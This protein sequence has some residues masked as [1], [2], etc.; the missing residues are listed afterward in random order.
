MRSVRVCHG[1]SARDS[2]TPFSMDDNKL[3]VEIEVKS[4]DATKSI[5]QVDASLDSLGKK[6][7][8]VGKSATEA[9]TGFGSMLKSFGIGAAVIGGAGAAFGQLKGFISDSISEGAQF[10][11][12]QAQLA[13]VLSSTGN[14][15]GFTAKQIN[16][17]AGRMSDLSAI[18]DDVILGAQ[19]MLLT[20]TQLKGQAFE[21]ATQAVLDM[22]TAMAGGGV[23]SMEQ[24]R[25]TAL[26]VGKALNDPAKGL[27]MLTRAGVTFTDQQEKQINTMIKAGNTMGAQKLML[28]ELTKEFGGSAA[29]AALTYEGRMAKL[30]NAVGD[31]KKNIGLAIIAGI[32]P[33]I[34]AMT[35]QA[36]GADKATQ[37]ISELSYAVYGVTTVLRGLVTG[38]KGV[39]QAFGVLVLGIIG[40][41]ATIFAFAK[42]VVKNFDAIK[43]AG[44]SMAKGVAY[45]LTGQFDD[46]KA[47]FG[48]LVNLDFSN[49]AAK[50]AQMANMVSGAWGDVENTFKEA[51]ATFKDA[52]AG[53]GLEASV[54]QSEDAAK[55][56]AEKNKQ[57]T[58]L[59]NKMGSGA[60]DAG[61]KASDAFKKA[62]S[63]LKD[64]ASD[65]AKGI[66]ETTE[67]YVNRA[68]DLLDAYEQKV[69]DV[70]KSI[71]EEN[72]SY[73]K[74]NLNA[75]KDYNN[76]VLALFIKEQDAHA[77]LLKEKKDLEKKM[78]ENT[79]GPSA[80]S[81]TDKAA[82][83]EQIKASDAKIAQFK[84]EN[85]EIEKLAATERGKT[86]LDKLKEQ[87]AVETAE[88]AAEHTAKLA[89]LQTKMAEELAVY[90]KN[91][92]DLIA[93]TVDKYAKIDEKLN[94]GWTK[95]KEDTKIHVK[96]MQALETQVMAIKASIEAAR[97]AVRTNSVASTVPA[98]GVQARADGGSVYSGRPY[99]VG[100]RGPE[101]FVP[102]GSGSIVP[103]GGGATQ[104]HIMEGAS[105]S[106]GSQ[107]DINALAD[108]VSTRLARV[109]QQQRSGLA[110]SM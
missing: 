51:G 84:K 78:I 96:E 64:L 54:K 30:S 11:A 55:T 40:V 56:L 45:A 46:A 49:T 93:D 35:E 74:D 15:A 87:F 19:N 42:D 28:D 17:M 31:V 104:I 34:D 101:L 59:F 67:D 70:N 68:S 88:R 44:V 103:N 43:K 99:M 76:E 20:F 73:E 48:E 71:A 105:V 85:A 39:L 5:K 110:T 25:A 6:T 90:Q 72:A 97:A 69:K 86:D 26:Q 63:A 83:D 36:K 98:A 37:N 10:Q 106:V 92:E 52:F 38:V 109:L 79:N 22:S 60:D 13:A 33:M 8:S 50:Q 61:K 80:D 107:E 94:E 1:W 100:E 57:I 58:D 66:K 95:M 32:N 53:K 21:G 18:D 65:T 82:L 89:D 62:A 16:D 81:F 7:G 12:G 108:A 102:S 77:A 24:L 75:K 47:A 14:A 3:Q 91:K 27:T 23:P 4:D 29:L 41:G 9:S 2:T